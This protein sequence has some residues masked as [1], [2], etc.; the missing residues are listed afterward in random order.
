MTAPNY[1][2]RRAG[3]FGFLFAANAACAVACVAQSV[4]SALHNDIILVWIAAVAGGISITAAVLMAS[5]MIASERSLCA[6][7]PQMARAS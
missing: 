4:A 5:R 3:L 7:D 2:L 1:P 6:T